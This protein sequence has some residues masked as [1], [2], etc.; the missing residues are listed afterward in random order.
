MPGRSLIVVV[1][2]LC[3][4]CLLSLIVGCSH[5]SSNVQGDSTNT[6]RE[7]KDEAVTELAATL[8][9]PLVSPSGKYQLE[10]LEG[11]N[12]V[13]HFYRF[14]IS[15][16]GEKGSD[17]AVIFCSKDTFRKR[18]RVFFLWDDEDK[19]WVYSGDVGTYYWTKTDD[20]TWIKSEDMTKNKLE[21]PENLK[22]LLSRTASPSR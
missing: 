16:I 1:L 15:K 9:H 5:P 21:M 12:G 4:I 14:N 7:Q 20:E 2:S 19:V 17:P 18:D 8:E 11:Y 13:V 22:I 10:V 6:S 3:T